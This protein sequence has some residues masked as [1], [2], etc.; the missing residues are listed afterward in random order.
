MILA[1]L[2]S[3]GA[4]R[5]EQGRSVLEVAALLE[6]LGEVLDLRV[7][8]S[9]FGLRDAGPLDGWDRSGCRR[10]RFGLGVAPQGRVPD[11]E[12]HAMVTQGQIFLTV[13]RLRQL[14]FLEAQLLERRE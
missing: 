10:F 1:F 8:R 13:P 7:L 12:L 9:A 14:R 11:Q 4:A 6:L 3:P 5:P 2:T